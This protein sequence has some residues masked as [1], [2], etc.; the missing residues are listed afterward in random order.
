MFLDR[1]IK[2]SEVEA[3]A[4]GL[5]AHQLAK[6]PSTRAVVVAEGEDEGEGKKGPETVL[7]RASSFTFLL[8]PLSSFSS[9]LLSSLLSLC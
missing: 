6:L 2:P 5:Q 4:A 3:F 1:L 9:S 8:L 7:D